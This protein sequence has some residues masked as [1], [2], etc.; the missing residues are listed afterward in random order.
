MKKFAVILA[1]VLGAAGM[2]R[3]Q[4]TLVAGEVRT[5]AGP[6]AP[7]ATVT[8]C[9]YNGAQYAGA[10]YTG[11]IPCTPKVTIYNEPTL[12]VT[13]SNPIT[14]NQRGEFYF[15]VNAGS[16]TI[17]VQ[18]PGI[19]AKGFEAIP[20]CVP[21]SP[22]A[23]CGGGGGTGNV[24]TTPSGG[25]TQYI[26]QQAGTVF[27][28]NLAEFGQINGVCYAD[29][30]GL[31]DWGADVNA[32]F[33]QAGNSGTGTV[34]VDAR[35]F[36]GS[37]SSTTHI[38]IPPGGVLLWGSGQLTI[39]DSGTN[40][41]IELTGDG[42]S[43][44]GYQESGVASTP[45]GFQTF[46]TSGF[47][48][49]GIPGCT[50]IKN[51]ST[52]KKLNYAHIQGMYLAANGANSTVIN[53]TS[54]GHSVVQENSIVLGA[55]GSSYGIYI[56]TSTSVLDSGDSKFFHNNFSPQSAGDTCMLVEGISNADVIENNVCSL[57]HVGSTVTG[58]QFQKDTAGTPNYPNNE[59]IYGN[60]CSSASASFGQICYNIVNAKSLTMGPNNRC[61]H[62]YACVQFPVDGSATGI[63]LVD[64]YLSLSNTIQVEPNEP[65]SSMQA[66]DN[67]S[68]NWTPSIHYGFSDFGGPNLVGNAG[69]EGWKDST[70]LFYW[71][72][73]TGTSINQAGSGIIA[74]NASSGSPAADIYTQGTY[75]VAIGDNATAG[76]GINSACIQVD[77]TKNYTLAFRIAAASTSIKFR[78]GIR[79]YTDANCT[80]AD[81]ITNVAEN[82]RVLARANYMGKSS[83][84]GASGAYN[85]QSTNASLTYNNGINCNCNVTGADWTLDTANVWRPTRNYA[86]TFR[87]ANAGYSSG[88]S[89]VAHSMRVFI[90]ENTAANPNVIYVDDVILSQGAISDDVTDAAPLRDSGPGATQTEYGSLTTNGLQPLVPGTSPIGATGAPWADLFLGTST[91]DYGH[92]SLS[93]LTTNQL[94]TFPNASGGIPIL[95]TVSPVNGHCAQL[96]VSGGNFTLADAGAAC[97]GGTVFVAAFGTKTANYTLTT[98][99]GTIE[100]TGT[101][102]SQQI[103]VL[104]SLPAS[105]KA[106]INLLI[107]DSTQTWTV[108]CDSGNI[109]GSA[110]VTLAANASGFVTGDGTNCWMISGGS[111]S[112]ANLAL[113]NLSAV[114]IN[115]PLLPGSVNTVDAG[116]SAKPFRNFYVGTTANQAAELDGSLLTGNRLIKFPDAAGTVM[117]TATAVAAGQ[118]PGLTG[119]VTTSAG[120]VATTV[121]KIQTNPITITSIQPYDILQENAA[122]TAIVNTPGLACTDAQTG[123]TYTVVA[124]DRGCVVMAT[125]S[126]GQAYTLPQAGTTGFGNNFYTTIANLPNGTTPATGAVTVTTSTSVFENLPGQP[127]AFVLNQ[128]QRA[129]L[130]SADNANWW[131]LMVSEPPTTGTQYEFG[132]TGRSSAEGSSGS[133][134]TMITTPAAPATAGYTV[135][136]SLSCDTTVSAA[137]ITFTYSWTDPSGT[138][139][140]VTTSHALCT[141]L[142]ASSSQAVDASINVEEGT[143]ITWYT[144]ISGAAVYTLHIRLE[145]GW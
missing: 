135:H 136:A 137:Y 35:G 30:Q 6:V 94:W 23:S 53:M 36:T 133:P 37:N 139:Q 122:G 32:C 14:A 41:A 61:E 102:A 19:V 48:A 69:F 29:L 79:L 9:S 96:G 70:D 105:G 49:C 124:A 62:V 106:Q 144:A 78:P 31:G 15:Y 46:N 142:G 64:P 55:G 10:T 89:G 75:N 118:M 54:I 33:T 143:A 108:A 140:S 76:L 74:Q 131:V 58:F 81:R 60:D 132:V 63:H 25:V 104:H 83:L 86:I 145:G 27:G 12:M 100:M 77:A 73:V 126:G 20:A 72:A 110:S 67:T 44:Y 71:G 16:Y 1:L 4:G 80:E 90:L 91:T 120:A 68:E 113:S 112:G 51:P 109:N 111:G 103:T 141:T 45:S 127:S 3:A 130:W 28:A 65:T 17:T 21:N 121:G 119:D 52:T 123:T 99:D 92:F 134:I 2:V 22:N 18:G 66:I 26:T 5:T 24:T 13:Q 116:S 50:T 101:T 38:T 87:I 34:I 95:T 107:N 82:A 39:S 42:A 7:G 128:N 40:D 84:A 97:A 43:I 115:T 138:A 59:E 8:V 125:N 114:A 129:Y 57:P 117:L 98:S 11:P 56:N 85:W 88:D 93:N 47:I